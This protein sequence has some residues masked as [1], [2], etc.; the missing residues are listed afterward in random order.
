[1][2]AYDYYGTIVENAISYMKNHLGDDITLKL[3]SDH[4]L[5]SPFHFSRIF[6]E[7]TGLPPIEF[8]TALRIEK[9][10]ELLS[11]TNLRIIDICIEVGFLSLGTFTNRFR[12][13]VGV[14]PRNYRNGVCLKSNI[15]FETEAKNKKIIGQISNRIGTEPVFLGLFN[16]PIPQGKPSSCLMIGPETNFFQMDVGNSGVYYLFAVTG[17]GY[18]NRL[19]G[20]VGPIHLDDQSTNI[21]IHLK[22][23]KPDYTDPPILVSLPINRA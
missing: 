4:A 21:P 9:S 1:M 23:R 2:S 22:L 18:G 6:R 14:T 8:L 11:K 12:N 13:Y 3:M 16:K 5:L 10:K 7:K 17:I 19:Q 15:V 20:I